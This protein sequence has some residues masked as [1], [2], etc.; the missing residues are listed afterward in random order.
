MGCANDADV[1][2]PRSRRTIY[3]GDYI[4]LKS[5]P[6]EVIKDGGTCR[7][8]SYLHTVPG[9]S[10][11]Y[12]TYAPKYIKETPSYR[13]MRLRKSPQRALFALFILVLAIRL[14]FAFQTPHFTGEDSYYHIRQIDTIQSTGLPPLVDELSYSGRSNVFTPLFHYILAIFSILFTQQFALKVIPNV[15]AASLVVV[16]F[17]AAY[18]MTKNRNASL[19]AAFA[20]GFIPVFMQKTVNTISTIS[21]ILPMMFFMLYCFM[22]LESKWHLHAYLISIVL[23]PL[24]SPLAFLFIFGLLVYLLLIRLEYQKLNRKEV[25]LILFSTFIV[26]WIE[27]LLFKNAF[28]FHS[29]SLIWQNI[30]SQ[31]LNTYFK[32]TTIVEAL[33]QVGIIPLFFG[34]YT[35]SKYIFRE[36]NRQIYLLMGFAIAVALLLWLRLIRPDMGLMFLGAI[37]VLL[38]SQ[39][40]KSM[41]SYLD[42]TK[43][44]RQKPLLIAGFILIFILTSALP[45]ITLAAQAS[46]DAVDQEIVDALLWLKDNTDEDA[47]VLSPV[48]QG[49]IVTAIADRKTV[50]DTNFILIRDPGLILEDIR[51]MYTSIFLTKALEPL[52]KYKVGYILFSDHAKSEFDIESIRYLNDDCFEKRYDKNTQ[53][54]EV[55]CSLRGDR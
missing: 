44:E 42:K 5:A 40:F 33:Y 34:L 15:F 43:A 32:E 37:L 30:P 31:L 50:A 35:I 38:F 51:T 12:K 47:I 54:Y 27:L 18:E 46:E 11:I 28:L 24:L 7:T 25:E 13:P 39:S 8:T 1:T 23:L 36:K 10:R 55:R 52:D 20:S 16:I 14:Y 21:L 29:F 22:R 6:R 2:L 4:I 53:I 48:E 45:S 41:S 3:S 17:Y 26:V 19:M 9:G 49:N